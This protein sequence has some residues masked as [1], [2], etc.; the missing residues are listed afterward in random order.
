MIDFNVYLRQGEHRDT[1]VE[2]Q[3]HDFDDITED[4]ESEAVSGRIVAD[5]AL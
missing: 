1:P 5:E 4:H 2:L 3:L